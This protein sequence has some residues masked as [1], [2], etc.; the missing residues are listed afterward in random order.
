MA[1]QQLLVAC[2]LVAAVAA[3][4]TWVV[5]KANGA[6]TDFV[7]I[8]PALVAARDGDTILVRAGT[9]RPFAVSK[10]VTILGVPGRTRIDGLYFL[11]SMTVSALPAGRVFRARDLTFLGATTQSILLAA[12]QG[13]VVLEA[14]DADPATPALVVYASASQLLTLRQCGWQSAALSV[15]ANRS[16]VVIVDCQLAGIAAAGDPR[17]ASWPASEGLSVQVGGVVDVVDSAVAGG[18]GTSIWPHLGDYWPAGP[19]VVMNGGALWLRGSSVASVSAGVGVNAAQPVSAVVG[20]GIVNL[21]AR[22]P[23]TSYAGAPVFS[24][25]VQVNPGVQPGLS[26]TGGSLGG[27]LSLAFYGEP[28]Q[29]CALA[30]G[31]LGAV[32]SLSFGQLFLD[33]ATVVAAPPIFA[34]G[35]GAAGWLLTVPSVPRLTGLTLGWQ[36]FGLGA[37]SRLAL[38]NVA[39]ALLH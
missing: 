20:N 8:P 36:V 13:A 9:Y 1:W 34:D 17:V 6:G 39:T 30:V 14:M 28:G 16:R 27:G 2:G 32:Q 7:D 3:Q 10:G 35:F 26:L 25:R 22:V 18:A 19:A 38:S 15:T 11:Q 21:D 23:V 31:S 37:G 12:N 4:R 24:A 33:P 5:D 29:Q